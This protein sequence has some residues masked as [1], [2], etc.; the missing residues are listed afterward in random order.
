MFGGKCITFE[1]NLVHTFRY[2]FREKNFKKKTTSQLA[3]KTLICE[4]FRNPPLNSFSEFLQK[5]FKY[6]FLEPLENR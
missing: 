5:F 2:K 3:K 6:Y 4:L 1:M